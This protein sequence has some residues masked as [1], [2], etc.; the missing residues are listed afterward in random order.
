[1]KLA[2]P[3]IEQPAP[4]PKGHRSPVATVLALGRV[5]ATPHDVALRIAERDAQPLATRRAGSFRHRA[6]QLAKQA[7]RE[8]RD[9]GR[10]RYLLELAA[11]YQRT[12]DAL[13]GSSP[14]ELLIEHL[15]SRAGALRSAPS[16]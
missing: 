15:K 13:A 12:A 3:A 7:E 11:Q 14:R 9:E 5:R 2:W 4:M 1:M 16:D 6:H 10:R 8:V